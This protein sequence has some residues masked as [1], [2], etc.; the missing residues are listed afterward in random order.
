MATQN[1]S[2]LYAVVF[3]MTANSAFK[4]YKIHLK[5]NYSSTFT[6]FFVSVNW[7]QDKN[8]WLN[9][10]FIE[11]LRFISVYFFLPLVGLTLD[12]RKKGRL[13]LRSVWTEVSGQFIAVSFW[14]EPFY[15]NMYFGRAIWPN[16]VNFKTILITHTL[17]GVRR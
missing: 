15:R 7:K 6:F 10:F 4:L 17:Y 13:W 8:K 5:S 1:Y 12:I 2:V 3:S 16:Y 9:P 11:Y 14:G